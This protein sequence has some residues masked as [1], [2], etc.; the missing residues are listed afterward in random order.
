MPQWWA[1]SC[2]RLSEAHL[3]DPSKEGQ[4]T[5]PLSLGEWELDFEVVDEKGLRWS[6]HVPPLYVIQADDKPAITS[7]SADRI[8]VLNSDEV[9]RWW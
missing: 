2:V 7:L 3:F 1:E 5:A 6:P 9:L 4:F 8:N